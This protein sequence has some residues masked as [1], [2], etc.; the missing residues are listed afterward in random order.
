LTTES[1]ENGIVV[2]ERRIL[3][4]LQR[5]GSGGVE[6]VTL[7]L[8]RA[9]MGDGIACALAVRRSGGEFLREAEAMAPVYVLAP[10]HLGQFVSALR[11]VIREWQPTHVVTAAS[12]ITL[13]TMLALRLARSNARLI[14][15]VHDTHAMAVATPGLHGAM[16]H[17]FYNLLAGWSYRIADRVVAVSEGVREEILE[18]LG[19]EGAH[20]ETIY[21]PVI[22]TDQLQ[23]RT[24]DPA[25]PVIRIAALGRLARQKGF[26]VLIEAAAKLDASRAWRIDIYGDGPERAQLQARIA[27]LGLDERVVLRGFTEKPFEALSVADVFVLSSRHEGLPTVLV[28]A[29]AC[30]L[31]IVATDCPHGPREILHGGNLGRLVPVEDAAALAAAIED[32]L[33]QRDVVDTGELSK[34]ASDFSFDAAIEKW[35]ALLAR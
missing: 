13:L 34:R 22:R 9:L 6:R 24:H 30:G 20:V 8:M 10:L 17:R 26:D 12:D 2:T 7:N 28:E 32:A 1:A 31:Q 5:M 33:E 29:M 15:G 3:F 19:V 4:V 14:R 18:R 35:R 11:D 16:R 27:A 23:A 21:N 25:E